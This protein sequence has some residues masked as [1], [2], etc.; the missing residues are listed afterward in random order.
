[1][2][3]VRT[4]PAEQKEIRNG[5]VCCEKGC[6]SGTGGGEQITAGEQTGVGVRP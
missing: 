5:R 6:H 2:V 1:M 4:N 3:S